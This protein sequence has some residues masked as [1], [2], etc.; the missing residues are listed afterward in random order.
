MNTLLAGAMVLEPQRAAHAREMFRVLSDPAIYEFENAAPESE[1]WLTRRFA[2]LESR[3]SPNGEEKWLNWVVRLPSGELAGYVQA[4]IGQDGVAHIA[5]VLASRFWRQGIGSA[6]VRA[7]LE[8]LN[9]AYRV[10]EFVATLKAR[11][12]RSLALLQ[13]LGFGAQAPRVTPLAT[14]ALDEV[15]MFKSLGVAGEAA[16]SGSA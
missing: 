7:M 11:N 15:V 10:V 13:G 5:Y 1:E 8:E 6:A 3:R 12:H 16:S 2:S 14:Q 9:T 4:T